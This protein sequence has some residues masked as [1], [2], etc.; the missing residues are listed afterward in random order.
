MYESEK[1]VLNRHIIKGSNLEH[2]QSFII[3][4]YPPGDNDLF[5]Y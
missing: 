2:R 4:S 5:D 1:K 3:L